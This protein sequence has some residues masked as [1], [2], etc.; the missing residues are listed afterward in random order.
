[1]VNEARLSA[2]LESFRE[3]AARFQLDSKPDLNQAL[4]LPGMMES[5]VSAVANPSPRSRKRWPRPRKPSR[6]W[7]HF[8]CARAR[9]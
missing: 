4:R 8:V 6:N 3:L 5:H 1:M 2:W 7:T 9:P